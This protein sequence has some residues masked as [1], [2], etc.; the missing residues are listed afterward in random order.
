MQEPERL[1]PRIQT[2]DAARVQRE[3]ESGLWSL[4]GGLIVGERCTGW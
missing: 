2:Q 4:H 1:S 3:D